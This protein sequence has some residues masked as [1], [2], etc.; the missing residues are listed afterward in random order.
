MV[1]LSSK[2]T[3]HVRL[4]VFEGPLDLLLHLI[5]REKLDISTVSLAQVT[6]QFLAYI[7]EIETLQPGTLA[8]FLAMAAR[9]VWLK[10]R[11]L[12]PRPAKSDE[13]EEEDPGE[14]LARQLREYKRFKEAALTLGEFLI[15]GQRAFIRIA[16]TPE[17]ERRLS[18]GGASVAEFLAAIQTAFLAR[19]PAVSVDTVVTP[20]TLT[21]HDQIHKIARATSRGRSVTFRSLLQAAHDRVEIIVTLLAVLELLKRRRVVVAQDE[22]F[23]EIVIAE[24]P[25]APAGE[26]GADEG[27]GAG[28]EDDTGDEE[29]AG[30]GE[31]SA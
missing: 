8:D 28:E 9:L 20:F 18:P 2:D 25:G 4:P 1:P 12:L 31:E 26:N 17:L 24:A 3:Y 15:R 7:R 29:D 30:E 14:A 27:N 19:P 21:I 6:D 11:L 5:E 22:M 16:D 23:G 10:S 13:E